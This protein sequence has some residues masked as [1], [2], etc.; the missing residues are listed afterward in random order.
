M[1]DA[2]Y[3][4]SN[5]FALW[6]SLSFLFNLDLEDWCEFGLAVGSCQCTANGRKQA[7]GIIWLFE[8]FDC[9]QPPSRDFQFSIRKSAHDDNG[10]NHAPLF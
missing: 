10:H 6:D 9:P 4:L 1:H 3:L 2:N 5:S 7:F 8:I